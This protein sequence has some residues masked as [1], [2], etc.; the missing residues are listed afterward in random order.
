MHIIRDK[1][2]LP[3]LIDRDVH[4][5]LLSSRYSNAIVSEAIPANLD[6]AND[7]KYAKFK[8]RIIMRGELWAGEVVYFFFPW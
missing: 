6:M 1:N 3:Y 7:K 8:G 4:F 5:N 2:H